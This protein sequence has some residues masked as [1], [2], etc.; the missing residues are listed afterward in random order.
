MGAAAGLVA[1]G[2]DE[3]AALSAGEA[4]VGIELAEGIGRDGLAG[5]DL[6]REAP[7]SEVDDDVDLAAGSGAPV[8]QRGSL[9][10]VQEELAQLGDDEGLE[11]GATQGVGTQVAGTAEP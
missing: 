10:L 7:G 1:P 5:L 6:H 8:I 3:D 2:I 11:D 9:S 4:G